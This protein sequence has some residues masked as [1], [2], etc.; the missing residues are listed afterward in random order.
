MIDLKVDRVHMI[1]TM[2]RRAGEL[3]VLLFLAVLS[4]AVS[5]SPKPYTRR[6][7][8]SEGASYCLSWRL[9][10][11]AN[12][13]RMWRTV[14]T[15]CLSHIEAY[16][17]G[18]QYNRDLNL[19]MDHVINYVNGIA[20]S[21]DGLDAFVLDVDDTCISNIF[22]YKGKRFGYVVSVIVQ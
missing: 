22:F 7:E 18:G 20:L 13:I 8:A 15:Q 5:Y 19:I 11:E 14:P 9:G 4:K 16:M 12:N 10:V 17:V 21:Q 2:M 3:V 6:S 1:S